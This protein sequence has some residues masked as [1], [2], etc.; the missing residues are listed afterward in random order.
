MKKLSILLCVMAV[1]LFAVEHPNTWAGDDVGPHYSVPF[2]GYRQSPGYQVGVSDYD[3]WNNGSYGRYVCLTDV[4]GFHFYYTYETGGDPNTRRATYDY[5]FP[6]SYWL[7]QTTL[8]QDASRMGA[9]DQMPDGRG[10]GSAHATVAGG[11]ATRVY[12]DAAEGAGT[13]TILTLPDSGTATV[14]I[15]PEQVVDSAGVIYVIATPNI[16]PPP[17]S[18]LSYSTDEGATW[19]PWDSMLGS[20]NIT[21]DYLVG[22]GRETW[23]TSPDSRWTMLVS[24]NGPFDASTGIYGFETDGLGT[25][26]LNVIWE[27]TASDSVKP[28]VYQSVVYGNDLYAHVVFDVIDTTTSA[29]PSQGSGKRSQIWHWYQSTGAI[30]QVD[31]GH[32]WVTTNPGCGVNHGTVSEP[33]LTIDKTT[34]DLYC[35]W[36]YGDPADTAANGYINNDIWGARSTDNGVT[37]IQ[38]HNI[39]NSPSPGAASGS[40][41]NDW[42]H[43]LAAETIGDTLI[44]FYMND[45]QAGSAVFQDATG[46]TDNPLLF[47]LYDWSLGVEE[48]TTEAPKRLSLNVAPNPS[49]RMTALSYALPNAGNVS[50]K[51][52]S[53][54]G[55]LVENVYNG[56]RDAGVYTENVNASQLANGTY[57]VVLETANEKIT[58]S[59]VVVR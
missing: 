47:Y 10:L 26:Y 38:H 49:R 16:N 8:D 5:H 42:Y 43:T 25:W 12:L 27:T 58:S 50:I 18:Y 30:S 44:I 31:P 13:F 32:G 59:L 4:G 21:Q 37:W 29:A 46:Y 36:T 53:V 56:R 15:W 3:F 39:T 6:P 54:D 20:F 23:G 14:P 34:G 28:W 51:L 22:S 19:T 2:N 35:T 7:G 9:L 17:H 11:Y 55:R 33:Q 1:A 41:D 24:A 48:N 45:K 40:C 52:Y 57:F